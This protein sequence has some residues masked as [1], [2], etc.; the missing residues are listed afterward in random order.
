[1]TG[2]QYGNYDLTWLEIDV[3]WA[4]RPAGQRLRRNRLQWRRSHRGP[5]RRRARAHARHRRDPLPA[6][7]HHVAHS[8]GLPRARA[9][10]RVSHRGRSPASTWKGRTC[11]RPTA[12]AARIRASTSQ[13]ASVDDFRRRQDAADGRI[14]LVTLAPEVPGALPLI[15]HLVADRCA[16]RDRPHGGD[17]AAA[18]AMRS[19]P[20]RRWRRIWATDVR[21]CC[22]AIRT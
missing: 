9:S 10:C 1:M 2:T 11:R 12:R 15:E 13:P 19:P 18:R 20:A 3:A 17:A 5:R 6:D 21:R 14:V 4:V 16:R 22:R 7:A 8:I